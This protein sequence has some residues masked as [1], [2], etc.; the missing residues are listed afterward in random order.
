MKLFAPSNIFL[1]LYILIGL[2]KN[3]LA[4]EFINA[5]MTYLESSELLPTIYK[6]INEYSLIYYLIYI[7]FLPF[8][9]TNLQESHLKSNL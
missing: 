5:S 8:L 1:M 3:S 2:D 9:L 6:S 7:I 4:P